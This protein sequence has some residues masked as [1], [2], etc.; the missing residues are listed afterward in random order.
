M[1]FASYFNRRMEELRLNQSEVA[2]ELALRGYPLSRAAISAWSTGKR[3]PDVRNKGFRLA[4]ASIL[5]T[6]VEHLLELL[7]YIVTD[8]DHTPEARRAAEIIDGL[9]LE[10]RQ[11]ALDVLER[12]AQG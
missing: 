5:D 9:S 2:R 12:L 10:R 4:L 11:L 3:L 7:D 1:K 6:D 8:I